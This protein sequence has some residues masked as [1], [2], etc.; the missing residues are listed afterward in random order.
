MATSE[1]KIFANGQSLVGEETLNVA[2]LDDEA[3]ISETKTGFYSGLASSKKFNRVLRQGTAG[4]A[5]LADFI[6]SALNEDVKDNGKSFAEQL[7]L[8]IGASLYPVG[9][10]YISADSTDPSTLFGGTWQALDEGRVLIGASSKYA[11][12]S[13]GGEATHTLTADEMPAHTHTGTA[14]SAG[15]HTHTRGTQEISSQSTEATQ[16]CHWSEEGSDF[17]VGAMGSSTLGN[18]GPRAQSSYRT[19]Y[20]KVLDFYASR[21]WSGKSSSSGAH[22]HSLAISDAGAG[23]AHNNMPPYLS[24]Y[25]WKRIA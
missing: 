6:T 22:S 23:V 9:A 16:I 3:L 13:K 10:I 15:A 14:S 2:P 19:G 21:A 12:G 17:T 8:A 1:F 24:V 20:Y 18:Y 11:A 5:T 7:K 25:M 4:T